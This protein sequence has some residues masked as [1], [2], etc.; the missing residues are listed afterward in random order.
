MKFKS[1]MKFSYILQVKEVN[2]QDTDTDRMHII[3]QEQWSS[4]RRHVYGI[5]TKAWIEALFETKEPG[6]KQSANTFQNR[7]GSHTDCVQLIN[8]SA[9][10]W[11]LST[12]CAECRSRNEFQGLLQIL[13][14][15]VNRQ[16]L[17]T[18]SHLQEGLG[19]RVFFGKISNLWQGLWG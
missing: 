15:R 2:V 17:L 19:V 12:C 18:Q 16:P 10:C 3:N 1:D 5:F 6:D 14:D 8:K 9:Y 11:S 4:H 13:C 7:S